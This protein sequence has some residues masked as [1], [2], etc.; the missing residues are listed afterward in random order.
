MEIKLGQTIEGAKNLN[1]WRTGLSYAYQKGPLYRKEWTNLY[2]SLLPQP[3]E[4]DKVLYYDVRKPLPFADGIFDAVYAMH[5][6]EHLSL[7]EGLSFLK[8]IK[9]ALKPGG[10]CRL[11]TPDL[12]DIIRNYFK[13]FKT[14]LADP[15]EINKRNYHWAQLEVFDQLSR[16]KSG[17][18]MIGAI[19]ANNFDMNYLK[20]RYGDVSAEFHLDKAR[21]IE[22][23]I[24]A[25]VNAENAEDSAGRPLFK[26]IKGKIRHK[27]YQKRLQKAIRAHNWDPRKMLEANKWM[28][29]RLSLR[30]LMEEA[31]LIEYRIKDYKTSDI[32]DW[33]RFQFDKSNFG[34]NA[35]E[36]SLYVEARKP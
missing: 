13:Q 8:E 18:D 15:S 30:L 12:E 28:H 23:K 10:I 24:R 4:E 11:S 14:C 19:K 25:Q 33:G 7:K 9:R 17:G 20:E 1:I 31:G 3:P 29:D 6:I 34:D 22:E 36:P 27:L 5:I 26:K 16:R 32:Q 21:A 35:I 2:F